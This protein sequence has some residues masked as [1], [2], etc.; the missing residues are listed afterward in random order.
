MYSAVVES[1][2]HELEPDPGDEEIGTLG[3]PGE[4]IEHDDEV[5]H[6]QPHG[7]DAKDAANEDDEELAAVT[8]SRREVV[9][10]R[11][12]G[13][14]RVDR[15]G[16]VGDRHGGHSAPERRA[17]SPRARLRARFAAD[18]MLDRKVEQVAPPITLKYQNFIRNAESTTATKRNAIAPQIPY[19]ST[20][21][22][23][24]LGRC[25]TI[26]ASTSA[27]SA[28]SNPSRKTEHSDVPRDEGDVGERKLEHCCAPLAARAGSPRGSSELVGSSARIRPQPTGKKNE[29]P[30]YPQEPA[31]RDTAAL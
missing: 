29:K 24:R 23:S 12:R 31:C 25:R 19:C 5:T 16:D 28:L 14:D 7:D 13:E 9:G 22:C 8:E 1:A 4:A 15:E 11:D 27:L 3:Q 20:R 2:D 26:N 30:S 18:E 17:P 6:H 10:H 21:R